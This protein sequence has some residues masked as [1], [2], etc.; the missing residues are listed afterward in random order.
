MNNYRGK[1]CR[2]TGRGNTKNL[3]KNCHKLMELKDA[4]VKVLFIMATW[5]QLKNA[6][7]MGHYFQKT[8]SAI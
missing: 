6:L 4:F 1:K 3:N 8:S 7:L 5:F 2:W